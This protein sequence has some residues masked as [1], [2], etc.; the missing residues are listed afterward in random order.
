M[1]TF[2]SSRIR[3]HTLQQSVVG[4]AG[5]Q[6]LKIGVC[7]VAPPLSGRATFR[8]LFASWGGFIRLSS[9]NDNACFMGTLL[10]VES[11]ELAGTQ[12]LQSLLVAAK[13]SG[14]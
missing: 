2:T 6:H 8:K 14:G 12:A 3:A 10:R 5:S 4:G 7:V 1:S 9:G 13:K 11:N